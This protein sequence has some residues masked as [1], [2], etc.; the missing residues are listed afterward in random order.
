[1][2]FDKACAM[3]L[4]QCI[5][6][7]LEERGLSKHSWAE[8]PNAAY[9]GPL[10][11]VWDKF[12]GSHPDQSGRMQA[13]LPRER[14]GL[15]ESR[16]E[17]LATHADYQIWEPT[18][19]I[20]F[21]TT[22]SSLLRFLSMRKGPSFTRKLTVINPNVRIAYGLPIV[23]MESELKYYKVQ[24]LYGRDYSYYKDEYLCL[25][26]VTPDE[27]VDHWN[28]DVLV[29]NDHWYEDTILPAFKEYND[30]FLRTSRIWY[31]NTV[32]RFA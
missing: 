1:M 20:S 22:V 25:W 16:K 18:L 13:R 30:R 8:S 32:K 7:F 15:R 21:Y 2:D 14:L 12:S 24:D 9:P 3:E 26:E 4:L 5:N 27:V 23:G 17:Y 19:F 29:E 6:P 28:W 31:V 11:R 10:V